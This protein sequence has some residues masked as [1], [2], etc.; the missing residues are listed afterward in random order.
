MVAP[1]CKYCGQ[2][3]AMEDAGGEFG[4]E[5]KMCVFNAMALACVKLHHALMAAGL[6]AS[7]QK[8][9]GVVRRVGWE[10]ADKLDQKKRRTGT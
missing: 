3:V 1:V 7:G 10:I 2:R 4:F 9:H 5:H 8:M 6:Y